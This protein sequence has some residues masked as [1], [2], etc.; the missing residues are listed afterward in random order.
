MKTRHT[1]GALA[2]WLYAALFTVQADIMTVEDLLAELSSGMPGTKIAYGNDPLQFGELHVPEGDG[3]FPVVTFIHGGCWLAQY[4][5]TTTRPLA[6]ALRD[7]GIAVWNLEYRRVGDP[8]G[9]YPGLLLDIGAGIDH[10]RSLA[11]EHPLDLT[12]VVVMGHSAGGHLALWAGA[13]AKIPADHDLYLPDPLSLAGVVAL[14]PAAALTQL[15]QQGTCDNVIDR[16]MHGS[17]AEY[18]DRY[19]YVE[20]ARMAPIGVRHTALMGVHD[21]TW[22]PFGEAYVTAARAI[23]DDT[24]ERV[25]APESGHFEVINPTSSTWP[26]VLKAV[27]KYLQ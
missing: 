14:A 27:R 10:L 8:G 17:P 4:D 19:A 1:L 6:W 26:L 24:I 11:M 2:L 3:P 9:T 13:R 20:P 23:G 7:E 18:P 21:V 5:I 15:H 22:T 12:Q 16:L 25:M